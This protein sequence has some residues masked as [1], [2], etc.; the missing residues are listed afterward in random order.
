M[1]LDFI[2]EF[3]KTKGVDPA[4]VFVLA[5][6]AANVNLVKWARRKDAKYACLE[7]MRPASTVDSF[8]G[9]E[10]DIAVVIMGTAHPRPGPGFTA[11][12]RRLNVSLSLFACSVL[13]H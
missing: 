10:G 3:T 4:K 7:A 9:Q 1:A 8:Q 11:D 2:V 13:L 12:S 5:P 6:Y